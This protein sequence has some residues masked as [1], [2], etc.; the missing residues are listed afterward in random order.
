IVTALP[1]AIWPRISKNS[2]NASRGM[3]AEM[4]RPFPP[5]RI[6]TVREAARRRGRAEKA[7]RA[8][9]ASSV[10]LGVGS[11]RAADFIKDDYTKQ[12]KYTKRSKPSKHT[13]YAEQT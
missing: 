9:L 10:T 4:A 2:S 12:S 11:L 7:R 1:F 5:E 3:V 6:W 13:Q 8:A